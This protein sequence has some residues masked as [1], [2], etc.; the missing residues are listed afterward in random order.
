MIL[1]LLM[2]FSSL[3]A[4]AD[5][6]GDAWLRK[7]D[8]TARVVD[9]HLILDL[10]VTDTRGRQ[11]PRTVEIWQKG[12]DRR[13]V[14]LIAPP[15]LAGIGL[16]ASPGNALHLYLPQYPPARRVIESKRA[17][18]FMGTDFA[19]EDLSRMT[20][21]DDYTASVAEQIGRETHL[22]LTS[23]VSASDPALHVWVDS[24]AV[25]RK[26]EHT[27]S[28]GLV[29]RRLILDDVRTIQGTPIPHYMKVTDLARNRVTEARIQRITIGT[30]VED[31]LFSV[32]QLER[33]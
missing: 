32:S 6:A 13:L 7:I 4:H 9:A 23:K 16:L 15:R 25:V 33:Q 24:S 10:T 5:P 22:V 18:A 11:K 8:K 21:S 19:I 3:T 29:S 20:F 28:S 26:I 2:L 31:E 1:S 30:N 14:R 17:D 12:D 27:D